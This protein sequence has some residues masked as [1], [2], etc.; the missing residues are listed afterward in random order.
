VLPLSIFSDF[1]IRLDIPGKELALLPYSTPQA[2]RAGSIPILLNNQLLFVKGNVNDVHD[3]YFL[4]DTGASYTAIS[5]SLAGQLHISDA[6]AR[7]VPLQGGIADINAPLL[8]GSVRLRLGSIG[9]VSG[10]VVA[11]DLSTASRYHNLEIA[12]LIGYP[13][14]RDSVLVVSY[15]DA[16][17]KI[18][19]E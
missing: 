16:F 11:V 14:L 10:P 8:N 15:R 12:G 4:L 2:D 13:A 7:R 6:L 18:G 1:L 5:R 19:P 9:P 3:G 17:I